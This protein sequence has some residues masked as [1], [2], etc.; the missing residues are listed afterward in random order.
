MLDF[1]LAMS[2][3]PS[4]SVLQQHQSALHFSHKPAIQKY[5]FEVLWTLE[6]CQDSPLVGLTNANKSRPLTDR[7]ICHEDGHMI[8][9]AEYSAIKTSV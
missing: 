5:P 2:I 4:D 7:V 6:N 9:S 8:S 1:S 3:T